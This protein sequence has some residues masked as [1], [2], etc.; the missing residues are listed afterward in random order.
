[1]AGIKSS[2]DTTTWS[3]SSVSMY[4]QKIFLVI[5]PWYCS[6]IQNIRRYTG[7]NRSIGY[8]AIINA[9]IL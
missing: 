1:M 7:Y 6:P 2:T 9:I 3:L 8:I 4:L 5:L